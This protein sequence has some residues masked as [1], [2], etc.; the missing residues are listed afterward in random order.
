MQNLV[1]VGGDFMISQN[2]ALSSLAAC[3]NLQTVEGSLGII[4]NPVLTSLAGLDQLEAGSLSDMI[5]HDNSALASCDVESV[6]EYL[7]SPNGHVDIYNNAQ[8]CRNPPEIANACGF[9]LSCLPY[10]DYY[11]CSQEDVD[12]FMADYS[13]CSE[14]NGIVKIS[15]NDITNLNGLNGITSVGFYLNIVQNPELTS[16]TGLESLHSVSG[17]V[18]IGYNPLLTSL[19]GLG[20]LASLDGYLSVY[21][22]NELTSL[23]GLENLTSIGDMLEIISNEKLAGLAALNNLSSIGNSLWIRNNNNLTSLSGIDQLDSGSITSLV[24]AFNSQLTTCEV[25]SIC[26]YL[27]SPGGSVNIE[28]NAPGCNSPG[29]VEAACEEVRVEDYLLNRNLRIYPNPVSGYIYIDTQTTA[30]NFE[31]SI[32]DVSGRILINQQFSGTL[33]AIDVHYLESG[34]YF[35]K[36]CNKQK[37]L[38]AGFIKK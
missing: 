9:A 3:S 24:I 17:A 38:A 29:E 8:G 11:L 18:S 37:I 20:N 23:S 27:A 6:C 16:L 21:N 10:G 35:V 1:W 7:G 31:L 30:D 22:N 13:D 26:N 2:Q 32:H 36:M 14:T 34:V 12:N 15:G 5:I 19:T 25:E 4:F 28:N 33:A